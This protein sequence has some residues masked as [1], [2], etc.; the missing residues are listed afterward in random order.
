MLARQYYN[1]S[2]LAKLTQVIRHFFLEDNPSKWT[3]IAVTM[4]IEQARHLEGGDLFASDPWP[5]RQYSIQAC[6]KK[7]YSMV[8]KGEVE[9]AHASWDDELAI[10]DLMHNVWAKEKEEEMLSIFY[11]T[12]FPEIPDD[13]F[14]EIEAELERKKVMQAQ[15]NIFRT[16]NTILEIVARGYE[17]HPKSIQANN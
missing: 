4:K 1:E 17:R 14:K 5:I 16:V 13:V 15:V 8:R 11:G 7:W 3:Y 10:P 9:N 2:E 12:D 6:Q